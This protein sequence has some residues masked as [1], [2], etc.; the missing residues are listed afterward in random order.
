MYLI[1]RRALAV[2][3]LAIVSTAIAWAQVYPDRP[4]RLVVGFPPGGSG[5]FLARIIADELTREIGQPVVVDN[6]PGAA[7]N[8]AAEHVARAAP[9][10][11]TVLL[12]GNFSHAINPWLY[13]NLSW[14]P[15][16]DF[17]PITKVALMSIIVCVAP[18]RGIRSMKELIAKVRSEPRKWFYATPGNGTSQH[19]AGVE[20]NR[21][22]GTDMQHV[23]FKG[24]APSLQAVLAGDVQV[25][26]GT[27]PVVLPQ[28]RAG[29]LVPLALITRAASPMVPG[30]PGME[31]AGVPGMD[32]GSWWGIWAPP[33]LRPEVKARLY[34]ALT[35]VMRLPQVAEK[36]AR[37]AMEPEISASPQEFAA[38]VRKDHAS[39]EAIVRASGA[40]AD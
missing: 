2:V 37:E 8:I 1:A 26:I 33:K 11:H 27:T 4:L 23:P 22:T 14:D 35:K 5:D 20:L 10:G 18:E 3:L 29:K 7:S 16:R 9:D 13:K 6:K 30:V 28:I 40:K 15:H 34:A 38:F 17:T 12:A 32:L 24:G 31:D 36:L 39:Y 21:I 19:L 25:M